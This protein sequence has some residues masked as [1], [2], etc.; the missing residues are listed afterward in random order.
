MLFLRSLIFNA[1]LYAF[2]ALSS[3]IAMS[4][5]I[6]RPSRLPGFARW[7]SLTWLAA[8]R[9]ICGVSYTVKGREHLP[10]G[11]CVVA[12]KHQSTW[13]TFAMFAVFRQPVFVFKSELAR[14]PFF[15]WTL[16]RLGCIPVTR[17]SGKSALDSMIEGTRIACSR[18]KQV[19]IFPEGTRGTVGNAGIYKSGVSHLYQALE[20]ACVP[21]ALNSGLLWPRRRFLRPPGLITLEILAPIPAG[22]ERKSMQQRLEHD[23]ETASLR[24]AGRAGA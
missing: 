13:D 6:A 12:M 2:T 8:Y 24:L 21:V 15:G 7:W 5:A 14:I 17:G 1:F 22:L 10:E 16:L 23:I 11:G 19:V 18:G 3:V 9:G 4:I 20:L